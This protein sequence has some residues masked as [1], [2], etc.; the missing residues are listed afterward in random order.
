MA[1]VHPVPLAAA[2][3]TVMVLL[4]Q[5]PTL[6]EILEVSLPLKVILVQVEFKLVPMPLAQVAVRA[7][8]EG[9]VVEVKVKL[10]CASPVVVTMNLLDGQS[11]IRNVREPVS[12]CVYTMRESL[13]SGRRST[14]PQV[15]VSYGGETFG[16]FAVRNTLFYGKQ[17]PEE[18]WDGATR[19]LRQCLA[20]G[21]MPEI[22]PY[23]RLR[24]TIAKSYDNWYIVDVQ[25]RAPLFPCRRLAAD[26]AVR[27]RGDDFFK[28]FLRIAG[29]ETRPSFVARSSPA[30]TSGPEVRVIDLDFDFSR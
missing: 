10:D 11:Q 30:V 20:D 19:L 22:I 1:L 26:V 15:V 7:E 12:A 6:Q 8:R 18:F 17:S 23:L 2:L 16:L 9:R 25:E 27:L 5:T 24:V 21:G 29:V 13:P 3:G 4:M 14:E 28:F